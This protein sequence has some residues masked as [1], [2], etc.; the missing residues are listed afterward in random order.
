M[1]SASLQDQVAALF[2]PGEHGIF[3]SAAGFSHAKYDQ[4]TEMSRHVHKQML[5]MLDRCGVEYYLFAG[6]MVGYVRNG[7]MPYRMDDLDIIIMDENI[8]TFEESAVPVFAECGFNCFFQK[9]FTGGGYHVL[10]MQQGNDR[11]LSIPLSDTKNVTV[12]WAQID[13]FY[14][15]VDENGFIRNPAAW[16]LYHNK[17]IPV[18]WVKPG[19]MVD[20]DDV[21]VRVFSEYEA[22]IRK[23]YGDVL[24]NIVIHSHDKMY[25]K[26]PNVP[27]A[28]FEAVFLKHLA[29]T[30]SQMPETVS[31]NTLDHYQSQ[32]GV[33]YSTDIGESFSA[34]CAGVLR[35]N[36]AAVHLT[37]GE[38]IFWVMDVK[39]L[40]PQLTIHVTAHTPL[41][42]QRAAHLRDFID[43]VDHTTDAVRQE[44]EKCIAGL[45]KAL[46]P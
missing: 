18:D 3:T 22:D 7:D 29:D 26:A 43:V 20:F 5:Q 42:A 34:I 27:W 9:R 8:Q 30:S 1:E 35:M 39:R 24:N 6:S 37:D 17:D 31:Q 46:A 19:V 15:T 14:S 32:A 44:Y 28:E 23:E 36:A 12:P 13:A 40:L 16:G 25:L 10:S 11:K 21:K 38:Q 33:V 45:R 4:Y 2:E 41:Q